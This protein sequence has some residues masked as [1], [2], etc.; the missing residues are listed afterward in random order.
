MYHPEINMSPEKDHFLKDIFI[1]QPSIFREYVGFQ[2]G[3]R[4]N[5]NTST[6]AVPSKLG[7][8]SARWPELFIKNS[9]EQCI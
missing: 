6:N 2:R 8:T 1:F 4:R 7:G 5:N 3:I 9:S